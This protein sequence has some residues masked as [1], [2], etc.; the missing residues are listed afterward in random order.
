MKNK[1]PL[2][3]I[4]QVIMLLVL[5]V[6]ATVCLQV[7]A[8][9]HHKAHHNTLQDQSLQQLEN[10]AQVLKHTKGDLDRLCLELGGSHTDG[11][12]ILDTE[13]YTLTA[14]LIE[15]NTPL[16]GTAE[17][18]AVTQEGVISSLSVSW[19]EVSP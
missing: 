19:Q 1:A 8:Q 9:A 2:A 13:A 10:T 16:L 17:L 6:A 15:D 7:F 11:Q 3:L 18:S 14:V 5:A 4:E 12:W